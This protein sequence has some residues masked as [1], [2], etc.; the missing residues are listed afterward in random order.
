MSEIAFCII[1]LG[2]DTPSFKG[3]HSSRKVCLIE[4]LR[5][6]LSVFAYILLNVVPGANSFLSE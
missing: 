4:V 3:D 1:K 6:A 2:K 5:A